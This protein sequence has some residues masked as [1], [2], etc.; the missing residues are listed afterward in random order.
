[1]T[2]AERL[3]WKVLRGKQ[4]N[5]NRFRRQHPVV[6][7]ILDFACAELKLA[8]EIDG[9]QH[10]DREIYDN[11]RTDFLQLSGWQILR[12][13]NDEVF[14]NLEGVLSNIS[15]AITQ[16]PHPNPPPEKGREQ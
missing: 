15:A 2:E 6:P 5:G 13:W 4:L 3:L 9:G 12:F 7:Y 1:M 11:N 14:K 10:Q 8:I 16:H